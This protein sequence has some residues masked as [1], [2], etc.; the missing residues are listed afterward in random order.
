LTAKLSN[1]STYQSIP[2]L[3]QGDGHMRIRLLELQPGSGNQP[4]ACTLSIVDLERPDAQSY[5]AISYV[6]G[7]SP[8][9][10]SIRINGKRFVISTVLHRL[11]I[12]LRRESTPRVLWIDAFCINQFDLTERSS[13]VSLMPRIYSKATQAIVWLGH[14]EPWGLRNTFQYMNSLY[15]DSARNER[16]IKEVHYG[17]SR[18]AAQLLRNEYWARVWVIQEVILAK[19]VIVQCG[20]SVLAWDRFCRLVYA[21]AR[22]SFFPA[23]STHLDKFKDLNKIRETQLSTGDKSQPA[24]QEVHHC[25]ETN[26]KPDDPSMDLL[27]LCYSFRFRKS[28]EPRDKVFAFLGLSSH[29]GNLLEVDYSRRE[30]F[31]SI[32]LSMHHICK[33]RSLSVVALAE[34]TRQQ[35]RLICP[36][37]SSPDYVPTWCPS[38]FDGTGRFDKSLRL[39]WTGFPQARRILSLQ[40]A[41]LPYL[42]RLR[43]Q[44]ANRKH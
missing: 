42:S 13:Q 17:I 40:Q 32:E 11:L 39:F 31:L 18:V 19:Q 43:K 15:H 26:T 30:S 20:D 21:S 27:S 41:A 12:H 6:W 35:S 34:S 10:S 36:I 23:R 38:F 37:G 9:T 25:R 14:E 24:P 33:F 2:H 22:R 3:I 7:T 16:I 8:W 44:S 29:S 5:E 1:N 4:V 28:T